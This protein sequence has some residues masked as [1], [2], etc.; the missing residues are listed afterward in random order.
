MN[1]PIDSTDTAP[2]QQGLYLVATPIGNLRDITLRALDVLKA[3]D[4]VLCEDSR[5]TGRLMH[6]YNLKKKLVVYNDHS[7]EADRASVLLRLESGETLALVSD[8]GTPMLSDPGFKLVSAC[9]ERGI[10]VVPIPGASALLPAL[11]L[12]GL[13]TDRFLFAGF[14]PHKSAARRT[15]FEELKNLRA[16]LVFYESP[17]RV[18]ESVVDAF[19]VLGDRPVAMA[20]EM[21]KLHEECR[22][23]TL[24]AWAA[25]ESL[26]GVLKGEAVLL[27][28]AGV[29]NAASEADIEGTLIKALAVMSVKDAAELVAKATNTPKKQVYE[30]ALRLK[31]A[32]KK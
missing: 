28:G 12:A 8:A 26:L 20:R 4:A 13:P 7:D 29:E 27:I 23:G 22:R 14:L 2:M 21:T 10:P 3:A 11:Q 1:D 9:L 24:A 30:M 6:A 5:V 15:V 18:A 25:N 31:D 32:N 16:T 17:N 19:A